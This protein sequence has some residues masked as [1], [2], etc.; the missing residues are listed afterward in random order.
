M[1]WA[2]SEE[3]ESAEPA[4]GGSRQEGDEEQLGIVR[5][6]LYA[7]DEP[8]AL[9][10]RQEALHR[11]G[12]ARRPRGGVEHEADR[13]SATTY[14][15]VVVLRAKR[16]G[17]ILRFSSVILVVLVA[18]VIGII[19]TVWYRSQVTVTDEHI[20]ISVAGPQEFTAGAEVIY[21]VRY[22]NR[23]RVDWHQVELAFTPPR[24]FTVRGGAPEL[25]PAGKQLVLA[26]G[27]LPSKAEGAVEIRG[28][29]LGE[30]NETAVAEANLTITPDNFPSG[31]FTR[32]AALATT[33]TALPLE[34]ATSIPDDAASGERVRAA[35]DVRNLSDQALARVY[36][37]LKPAPGAELLTN[38]TDFSAGFDAAASEWVL[39]QLQALETHS[40]TFVIAV[41]GQT[42]EQRQVDIEAGIR[43]DEEDFVQ[44][45]LTHIVS[46]SATEVVVDQ[47]FNGASEGVIVR[48]GEGVTGEVS[49]RNVG[50]VGLKDVIIKVSLE[51]VGYDPARLKLSSGAYDPTTRTIFWTAATVPELS[52]VQPQ[53]TGVISYSFTVMKLADFPRDP[54]TGKNNVM[55][56]TAVVDSPDLP[57]PP[58][59]P[60]Q[61]VSDRAVL[62][63][64]SEPI[65]T[66]M[67]FYDDGRLG[68]NSEGPLP[69]E[70][71][72][73]T[74]YTVRFRVGTTLNDVGDVALSAVVPDGASLTGNYYATGGTVT[75]NDRAGQVEWQL[76]Q[77]EGMTGRTLPP[78]E[79]HVQVAVVPGDNQRGDEVALLNAAAV[80]MVDQFTDRELRASADELPTTDTA[81]PG[82]GEVR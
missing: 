39:P 58:G 71:G 9:R 66:A 81:A 47:R 37:R 38:D 18:G 2:P 76:P 82:K 63:V 42:G 10:Q 4:G 54:A 31:R 55:V 49:F 35:I 51:G 23:S 15:N 53:E 65:F 44:R 48:P 46:I 78:Q 77:I 7:R 41:A 34:V 32:S 36:V 68:L 50:T 29:L 67:A 17:R 56:S 1:T 33:I 11:L 14:R 59:Q 24:G 70:V 25:T 62:A 8:E 79:L 57:A 5:R 6:G 19:G 61:V 64:E 28:Q 43:Q 74:T 75:F 12:I 80:R 16:W 26:V 27:E 21:T 20:A 40:L 13:L 45:R 73:R 69:P 22:G 60:R 72:Q 3:G 30:Q 52:V